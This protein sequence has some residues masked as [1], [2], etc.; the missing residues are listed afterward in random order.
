MNK[1]ELQ[2]KINNH[3]YNRLS[4]ETKIKLVESEYLMVNDLVP[5]PIII[6]SD[7]LKDEISEYALKQAILNNIDAFLRQLG[8]GF[9]YIGNEYKIK[10]NDRYNYELY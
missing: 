9:T 7:S 5:N 2:E 10:V 4:S 1:R 8:I 3:E 6:K